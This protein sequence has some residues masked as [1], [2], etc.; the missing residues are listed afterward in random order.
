MHNLLHCLFCLLHIIMR[1]SG[2]SPVVQGNSLL[3]TQCPTIHTKIDPVTSRLRIFKIFLG[4]I[5]NSR[6]SIKLVQI[7]RLNIVEIHFRPTCLTLLVRGPAPLKTSF[8]RSINTVI[9]WQVK[10]LLILFTS[11]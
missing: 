11:D 4:T 10:V 2:L 7:P 1:T 8:S 3:E 5:N 6:P 9:T